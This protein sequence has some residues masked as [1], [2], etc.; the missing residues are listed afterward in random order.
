MLSLREISLIRKAVYE[1]ESIF[2]MLDLKMG[3]KPT[4]DILL[5]STVVD[6]LNDLQSINQKIESVIDTLDNQMGE[7]QCI[8]RDFE[9]GTW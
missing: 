5:E 2:C 1:C 4:G 6:V 7:P 8:R 3:K 9:Y